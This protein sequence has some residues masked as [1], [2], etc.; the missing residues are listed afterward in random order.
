MNIRIG[1]MSGAFPEG[2]DGVGYLRELVLGV[3]AIGH[4]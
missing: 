2:K 4:Y 1:Y 3:S